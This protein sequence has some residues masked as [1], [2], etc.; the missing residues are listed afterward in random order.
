MEH[1]FTLN[2]ATLS[3]RTHLVPKPARNIKNTHFAITEKPTSDCVL[4]HNSVGFRVGNF[5]AN[6]LSFGGS[7]LGNPC[8]YSQKTQFLETRVFGLHFA[9][10]TKCPEKRGHSILC[11][12]LTNLATVL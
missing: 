9:A 1:L 8:E 5:E 2:T 4:L 6:L 3:T 10:Y 12:T 11:I 7:C